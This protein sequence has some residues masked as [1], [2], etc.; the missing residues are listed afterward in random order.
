MH[1]DVDDSHCDNDGESVSNE[2]DKLLS[3]SDYDTLYVLNDDML[4]DDEPSSIEDEDEECVADEENML[5]SM[6]STETSDE[7]DDEDL[8]DFCYHA[9][10]GSDVW[11]KTPA[12]QSGRFASQ[13]VMKQA[14]GPTE[15]ATRRANSTD[16]L[17]KS[18]LTKPILEVIL[19][20]SNKEG[21]KKFEG[22]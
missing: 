9:R 8:N 2:G 18:F 15:Y 4:E 1:Q 3:D 16:E 6:V 14:P 11:L 22:S 17:L 21:M 10:K 12:S 13:N 19:K 5:T 7:S 20:M